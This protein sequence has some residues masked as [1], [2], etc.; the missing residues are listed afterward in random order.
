MTE[1]IDIS[2]VIFVYLHAFTWSAVELANLTS[3]RANAIRDALKNTLTFVFTKAHVLFKRQ[4]ALFNTI[5]HCV[6]LYT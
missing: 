1:L 4:Y 5:R 2:Q 3:R 6:V